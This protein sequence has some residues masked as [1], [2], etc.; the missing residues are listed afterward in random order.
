MATPV[1]MVGKFGR[2]HV[3]DGNKRN[4]RSCSHVFQPFPCNRI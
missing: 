4:N 3:G 1:E 2:D